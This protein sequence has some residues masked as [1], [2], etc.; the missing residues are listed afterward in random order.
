MFD[1]IKRLLFPDPGAGPALPEPAGRAVPPASAPE[2]A[3]EPPPKTAPGVPVAAPAS[4]PAAAA[5]TVPSF[6]QQHALAE[7]CQRWLFG[8]AADGL[9]FSA[10]EDQVL[11]GLAALLASDQSSAELVGRMP[12]LVPQLLQCLRNPQFSGADVARKISGDV[13][14]VSA[15]IQLANSAAQQHAHSKA[16]ASIEQAVLVIG[17]E[18]L[19]QLVTA[20]AFRP[21]FNLQSGH[22]T[23][24]LAPRLWELSERS[25]LAARRLAAGAGVEPFDA[26]LAGLL[27]GVGLLVSLRVMDQAS[28]SGALGSPLFCARLLRM[29]HGLSLRVAQEWHFAPAVIGAIGEQPLLMQRGG[30]ALSDMGRLLAWADYLGKASVLAA[31]GAIDGNDPDLTG[32][33]PPPAQACYAALQ[34]ATAAP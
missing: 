16:I 32:A 18:G 30:A 29:A 5:A 13:V 4:G 15:V 6:E 8:A 1:W 34:G 3:P 21:I 10:R 27:L 23:R 9:D 22:Y 11:G 26:F 24:Q 12:G 2:P 17:Q 19:R 33:L 25:A 20:V 31:H 7:S 28:A 14:L